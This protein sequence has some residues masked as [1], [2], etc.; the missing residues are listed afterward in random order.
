MVENTTPNQSSLTADGPV[1]ASRLGA[2]DRA[3]EPLLCEVGRAGLAAEV[4]ARRLGMATGSARL[5]GEAVDEAEWRT[6]GE[7]ERQLASQAEGA[8]DELMADAYR[9][10][11][12]L[13]GGT[14]TE[15]ATFPCCLG[16]SPCAKGWVE[17]GG[18]LLS[19]TGLAA[20][21]SA[22]CWARRYRQWCAR[23]RPEECLL[24]GKLRGGHVGYGLVRRARGI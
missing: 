22:H 24:P 4:I 8:R 23:I 19:R 21:R 16:A 18:G 14:G 17:R 20:R 11:F 1:K 9:A 13:A 5:T 10:P 2:L 15:R 7:W 6:L 12:A 3:I